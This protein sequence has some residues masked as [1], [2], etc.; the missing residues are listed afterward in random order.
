MH[1]GR[2]LIEALEEEGRKAGVASFFLEVRKSNAA[3]IQLYESCGFLY[4]G[5]LKNFYEN[6]R[7]DGIL[8][9]K[10]LETVQGT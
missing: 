4:Q 8:M 9:H 5:I 2:S 7:E 10:D 3:A 6:P 1:I